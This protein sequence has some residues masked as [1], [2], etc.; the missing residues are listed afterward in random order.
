MNNFFTRT[1]VSIS[2]SGVK[3]GKHAVWMQTAC[4]VAKNPKSSGAPADGGQQSGNGHSV[5]GL[6]RPAASAEPWHRI[7][8]LSTTR[9]L[10][11]ILLW[12]WVAAWALDCTQAGV[13]ATGV[14]TFPLVW[15]C[16]MASHSAL[17]KSLMSIGRKLSVLHFKITS[18][19]HLSHRS[20]PQL[21]SLNVFSYS[22]KTY[23]SSLLSDYGNLLLL[24]LEK[25][26]TKS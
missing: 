6:S 8:S 25:R 22:D 13:C 18:V 11:L 5:L 9:D 20:L 17:L 12:F 10:G 15:L 19:I 1:C 2:V 24:L 21:F 26:T 16:S 23:S 7:I 3:G 14:H 4:R